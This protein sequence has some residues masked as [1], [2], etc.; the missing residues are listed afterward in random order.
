MTPWLTPSQVLLGGLLFWIFP[1]G[2]S[3]LSCVDCLILLVRFLVLYSIAHKLNPV[4][5]ELLHLWRKCLAWW[6]VAGKILL[7]LIFVLLLFLGCMPYEIYSFTLLVLC[8]SRIIH[9]VPI[10]LYRLDNCAL[11]YLFLVGRGM[12]S[13]NRILQKCW[14]RLIGGGELLI[15]LANLDWFFLAVV[16]CTTIEGGSLY[17]NCTVPIWSYFWRYVLLS[18]HCLLCD[19]LG[20]LID[21]WC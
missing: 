5:H 6:I 19:N 7:C 4:Q 3:M 1:L 18:L 2:I 12:C 14:C 8:N 16:I 9:V 20:E 10:M 15:V 17:L 13:C 11:L 21:N